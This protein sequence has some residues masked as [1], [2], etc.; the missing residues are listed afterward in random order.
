MHI[1]SDNVSFRCVY[2]CKI[3]QTNTVDSKSPSVMHEWCGL[4]LSSNPLCENSRSTGAELA[5]EHNMRS[6]NFCNNKNSDVLKTSDSEVNIVIG[7]LMFRCT[8]AAVSLAVALS[9]MCLG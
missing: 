9:L 7:E 8:S 4:R 1:L 2:Q 3:S 5:G 6:K